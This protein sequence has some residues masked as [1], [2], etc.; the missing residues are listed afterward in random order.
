MKFRLLYSYLSQRYGRKFKVF[1]EKVK[2]SD[3]DVSTVLRVLL[4]R[5]FPFR[6]ADSWN[7]GDIEKLK[8]AC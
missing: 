6:P 4:F 8:G 2:G 7:F 5:I 1:K 3:H